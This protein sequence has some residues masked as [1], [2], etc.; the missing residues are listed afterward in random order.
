MFTLAACGGA[1]AADTAPPAGIS[2]PTA[3]PGPVVWA[4]LRPAVSYSRANPP[5]TDRTPG[6][7]RARNAGTIGW[8][9]EPKVDIKVTALGCF[10]ADRDGLTRPHRVGIFDAETRRLLAS[11]TVRPGSRLEGFFRWESLKT[12]LVLRA[13]GFY[14][15]GTEDRG[16]LETVYTRCGWPGAEWGP[17]AGERWAQEIVSGGTP[18]LYV[19]RRWH[20]AFTAPT[21][22]QDL[23]GDAPWFSPNIKFR[24]ASAQSPAN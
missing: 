1:V 12:P 17:Q 24:A 16:T 5:S 20:R 21:F 3:S 2:S 13:E 8:G 7:A 22:C 15:V 14:V 18:G 19:N 9:F 10:D 23:W 6:S 11:V 4:S